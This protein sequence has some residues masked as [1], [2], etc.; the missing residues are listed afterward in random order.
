MKLTQEQLTLLFNT[1]LQQYLLPKSTQHLSIFNSI[2][3]GKI[4]TTRLFKI[5]RKKELKY[6]VTGESLQALAAFDK[7]EAFLKEHKKIFIVGLNYWITL[8]DLYALKAIY[9]ALDE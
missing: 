2:D 9:E 6:L 7:A 5:L 3:G 4:L 1:F 8:K